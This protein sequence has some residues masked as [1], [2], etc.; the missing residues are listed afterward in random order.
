MKLTGDTTC[1]GCKKDHK[2][3]FDLDKLDVPAKT[4]QTSNTQASSQTTIQEIKPEIVE[5]EVIKTVSPADVPFFPCKDGNCGEIHKNP[6]YSKAPNKK[7][8]HC[9]TL[10]GIKKCKNCKNSDPEEFDELDNE[11]LT[12]LGIPLP[13]ADEHEGH[14]HD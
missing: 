12:E 7:C 13:P 2:V 11:E 5:K 9:D 6:N 4:A 1:P 8:K 14:D 10:N 3:E